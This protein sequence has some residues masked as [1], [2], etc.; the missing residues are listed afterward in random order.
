[1]DQIYHDIYIYVY[2]Y[3]PIQASRALLHDF[4][5]NVEKTIKKGLP[6]P[7]P[8]LTGCDAL[9]SCLSQPP[10]KED[11]K[12]EVQNEDDPVATGTAV[13]GRETETEE[14]IPHEGW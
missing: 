7:L 4:Q 3:I 1:M 9:L 14:E 11:P 2:I 13:C 10:G 12:D 8:P 5:G 6:F